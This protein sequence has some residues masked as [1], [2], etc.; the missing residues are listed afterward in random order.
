MARN[1]APLFLSLANGR[2]EQADAFA[3]THLREALMASTDGNMRDVLTSVLRE[4]KEAGEQASWDVATVERAFGAYGRA[5]GD[6][7]K[8]AME[9]GAIPKPVVA[10]VARLLTLV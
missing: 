7:F 9:N 8:L 1:F 6:L 2:Q 3:A 4:M 5:T 10:D